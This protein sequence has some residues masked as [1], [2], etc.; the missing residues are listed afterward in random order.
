MPPMHF[1]IL[2]LHLLP[3]GGMSFCLLLSSLTHIRFAIPQC[4]QKCDRCDSS[5]GLEI[6]NVK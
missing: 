2:L 4:G 5:E 3:Q 1:S 6:K